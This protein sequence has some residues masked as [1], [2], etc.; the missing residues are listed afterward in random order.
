M[1][2]PLSTKTRTRAMCARSG[3][4]AST[5][6]RASNAS[7]T[8]AAAQ[9]ATAA[10]QANELNTPRM[11]VL[12]QRFQNSRGVSQHSLVSG[13]SLP[14]DESAPPPAQ[15]APVALAGSPSAGRPPSPPVSP[16]SLG[17]TP[18]GF[19]RSGGARVHL[20]L[21]L[22]L[23]SSRGDSPV[24]AVAAAAAAAAVSTPVTL[25]TS[26]R[27]ARS[28]SQLPCTRPPPCAAVIYSSCRQSRCVQQRSAPTQPR[29]A[30][31]RPRC[32]PGN[33][34]CRRCRIAPPHVAADIGGDWQCCCGG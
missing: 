19:Q 13:A 15:Y 32:D 7:A 34:C 22:Q 23:P 20:Q 3:A 31:H 14:D 17:L 1:A 11:R 5:D 21:Q 6:R 26:S 12:Q 33:G 9:A 27:H 24:L 4:A 28:R 30:R 2:R 18:A 16:R 29:A 25:S 8:A 10:V